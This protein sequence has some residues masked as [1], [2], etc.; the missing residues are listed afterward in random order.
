MLRRRSMPLITTTTIASIM[1][2]KSSVLTMSTA[3]RCP[4]KNYI[5]PWTLTRR[6]NSSAVSGGAQAT[7]LNSARVEAPAN[8]R[9][10]D[11]DRKFSR[12]TFGLP[13]SPAL[14]YSPESHTTTSEIESI[15]LTHRGLHCYLSLL[16]TKNSSFRFG[17]SHHSEEFY[18]FA[19]WRNDT[20]IGSYPSPSSRP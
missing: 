12:H 10:L 1:A 7:E 11:S 18:S 14:L 4:P 13:M 17:A 20:I 2:A 15:D 8:D 9:R 5:L 19:F 16:N 6:A 3:M